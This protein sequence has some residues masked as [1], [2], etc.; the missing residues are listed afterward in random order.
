MKWIM[1]WSV[2]FVFMNGNRNNKDRRE[3]IVKKSHILLNRIPFLHWRWSFTRSV[4]TI[5]WTSIKASM[6][7]AYLYLPF[8]MF[9]VGWVLHHFYRSM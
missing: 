7:K 3:T 5:M 4:L 9:D 8:K 2:D 6:K 1:A